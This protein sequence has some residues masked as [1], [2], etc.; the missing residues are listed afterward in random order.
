M[1]VRG[2]VL[3]IFFILGSLEA[4]AISGGT[5]GVEAGGN[6]EDKIE[7]NAINKVIEAKDFDPDCPILAGKASD[8]AQRIK[9]NLT[10][11]YNQTLAILK[12]KEEALKNCFGDIKPSPT[13]RIAITNKIQELANSISPKPIGMG[14]MIGGVEIQCTQIQTYRNTILS[15]MNQINSNTI[16]PPSNGEVKDLYDQCK[17]PPQGSSFTDCVVKELSQSESPLMVKWETKC[18]ES[19]NYLKN[20]ELQK[21]LNINENDQLKN[22]AIVAGLEG[23]YTQLMNLS[24]TLFNKEPK[25]EVCKSTKMN[26][27]AT[28]DSFLASTSSALSGMGPPLTAIASTLVSGPLR[29]I[30]RNSFTK[31]GA[32]AY[33][34]SIKFLDTDKA[35]PVEFYGCALSAIQKARCSTDFEEKI[36]SCNSSTNQLPES[37]KDILGVFKEMG[38]KN[39]SHLPEE[40]D[41]Q[42]QTT[43]ENFYKK[44]FVKNNGDKTVHEIL[45]DWEKRLNPKDRENRLLNKSKTDPTKCGQVGKTFDPDCY[46]SAKDEQ[47]LKFRKSLGNKINDLNDALEDF[48]DQ[49]DNGGQ[50]K[51]GFKTKKIK[52]VEERFNAISELVHKYESSQRGINTS[53][54]LDD[55]AYFKMSFNGILN[56]AL[57][58]ESEN[59]DLLALTKNS[60]ATRKDLNKSLQSILENKEIRKDLKNGFNKMNDQL[61][62]DLN[63]SQAQISPGTASDVVGKCLALFQFKEEI[64]KFNDLCGFLFKDECIKS[65]QIPVNLGKV[66][67]PSPSDLNEDSYEAL[68]MIGNQNQ[69]IQKNAIKEVKETK[70][71]CGQDFKTLFKTYDP[72]SE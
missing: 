40:F 60:H 29:S 36:E 39:A 38:N 13:D 16:T 17:S 42:V 56:G 51:A 18:S 15:V 20:K 41:D 9:Q 8:A 57:D 23:A 28:L 44:L 37:V 33:E 22:S 14:L 58:R 19:Y 64:K 65:L 32:G 34:A 68:C 69:Q 7:G 49:F 30:I 66:S 25:D 61:L 67:I 4:G 52:D 71:L 53:K 59:T 12:Q 55:L 21:L 10:A 3:A 31:T 5:G 70:K 27:A 48:K 45:E 50:L 43:H 6:P 24:E 2:L 47:A 1:K 46:G 63:Q 72:S 35:D 26:V 11:S 54:V 62:E